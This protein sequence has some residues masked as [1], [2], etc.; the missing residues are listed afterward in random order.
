M[1]LKKY[2]Y[3]VVINNKSGIM[4]FFIRLFFLFL[5]YAY[6]ALVKIAVF[7]YTSGLISK[8]TFKKKIV[9]IGN[10]TAGGT[11]KTPF[12][13]FLVNSFFREKKVVIISGG[14][15]SDELDLLQYNLPQVKILSGR[16]RMQLI[17]KA[18]N[19]F[20]P[21]IIILDDGF[22][23]WRIKKDIEIV[24]ID[25]SNPFSNGKLLP[26]GLLREPLASLMRAD[27]LVLTKVDE[28][29]EG[30]NSIKKVIQNINN[31]ALVLECNH[32]ASGLY[33]PI[34]KKNKN[35][36]LLINEKVF[37]FCAIGSAESFR[38]TL[39]KLNVNI[40]GYKDYLDHYKYGDDDIDAIINAATVS[41]AK[42]IITTEKDWMRLDANMVWKLSNNHRFYL[43]KIAIE[44]V[45][46]KEM[47]NEKLSQLFNN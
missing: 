34:N 12:E 20:N 29:S 21:D 47:L 28:C 9:S 10:I 44:L 45:D 42:I 33:E 13:I 27:V 36:K 39:K 35:L 19:L 6:F 3:Q 7:V 41:K 17:E 18:Q 14:Y 37:T 22:Q 32:K 5:S 40:A 1:K 16:N 2:L 30:L 38:R 43:L 11:G 8:A 4:A 15:N 31:K 25:S 46:K 26:A 23:Q 24:L